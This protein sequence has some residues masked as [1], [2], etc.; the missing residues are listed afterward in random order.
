METCVLPVFGGEHSALLSM[1]DHRSL[2]L[3]IPLLEPSFLLCHLHG[4]SSLSV[5]LTACT[6]PDTNKLEKRHAS[7]RGIELPVHGTECSF[8]AVFLSKERKAGVIFT[9]H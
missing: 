5:V 8:P 9:G 7:A 4:P 6:A 3:L 2:C 1:C